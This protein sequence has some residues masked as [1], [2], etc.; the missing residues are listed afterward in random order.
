MEEDQFYKELVERYLNKQLND[1]ELEVFIHLLNENKLDQYLFEAMDKD[2]E[3][4]LKTDT[5][6]K[7]I[8]T[9]YSLIYK[10]AAVIIITSMAFLGYKHFSKPAISAIEANYLT[11]IKPG[12]NKAIL[13]LSDGEKIILNDSSNT[14]LK[15]GDITTKK[16]E[17]GIIVYDV[18]AQQQSSD[19]ESESF[20]IITTPKG[21]IYQ[22]ILP[23]K[24]KVWLNNESSIKFPVRFS[25]NERRVEITGEVYFE[26]ASNKNKPFK[27]VSEKQ[28]VEVLGTKFNINTYKDEPAVKTTLLEGSVKVS[29]ENV[30]KILRPGEQAS[31]SGQKLNIY[32]VDTEQVVA[33]Y[34]GD[35]AFNDVELKTI[36]RQISRW[37]DVEVVYQGNVGDIK[38]GGSISKNKGIKEVLKV[39]S[40]TQGVNFKLE[41]RRVLV[42]P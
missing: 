34:R 19:S 16:G 10:A 22:V 21:G 17:E 40:M 41:G 20:N 4:V 35:F 14:I 6:V 5:P 28:V 23:D 12:S 7:K 42:M 1:D 30:A 36:M 31:I 38:F 9:H 26:V 24:T 29:L 13:T 37:Y 32:E 25:K 8:N 15:N 27:V 18:A 11:E 33:W 39:L 3:S 2:R